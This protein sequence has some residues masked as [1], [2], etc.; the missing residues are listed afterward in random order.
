MAYPDDI[1][2]NEE[3]DEVAGGEAPGGELEALPE[4]PLGEEM[5]GEEGMPPEEGAAA[6]L[7]EG[8]SQLIADWQPTTPE[9]EQYKAELEGMMSQFAGEMGGEEE[10]LP[11]EGGMPSEG[12]IPAGDLAGM[13]NEAASRAFR[14]MP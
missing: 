6:S 7:E 13:R 12:D 5:L 9:G 8:V 1:M 2:E 14:G 10:M 3:G 4:E 11:E